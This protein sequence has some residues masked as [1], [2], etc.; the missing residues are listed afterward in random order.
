MKAG[1]GMGLALQPPIAMWA[2]TDT[3]AQ[4]Q[5]LPL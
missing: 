5:F 3:L 2:Q 4:P 1:K